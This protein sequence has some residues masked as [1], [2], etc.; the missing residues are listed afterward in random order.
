MNYFGRMTLCKA[1]DQKSKSNENIHNEELFVSK[2]FNQGA[3]QVHIQ[4]LLIPL[5]KCKND[6]K[7]DK[8][9]VRI[10]FCRYPTSEKSDLY[11]FKIDLIDNRELEEFFLFIRN[12][13]ITIQA[14]GTITTGTMIWYMLTL[15]RGK[16]LRQ[17][18]TL[19]V[20]L[21]STTSEYLKAI[22]LG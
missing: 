14:S 21:G 20:D 7:L 3:V 18:N 16:A 2:T 11:E 13:Q 5:I 4:T 22:I 12:F 8:Y 10:K 6:D 19:S 9:C 15:V 17:L 1:I